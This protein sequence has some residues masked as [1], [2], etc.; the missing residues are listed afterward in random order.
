MFS[1]VHIICCVFFAG[2]ECEQKLQNI[3]NKAESSGSWVIQKYIGKISSKRF[4][5]CSMC[6]IN[7]DTVDLVIFARF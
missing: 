1:V 2:I 5:I 7:L 4:T 6:M 3:L